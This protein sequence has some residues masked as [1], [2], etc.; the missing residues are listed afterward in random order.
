V[1][2]VVYLPHFL[3]WVVV[4]ALAYTMLSLDNGVVNVIIRA[5][6]GEQKFFL[7]DSSIFRYVLVVVNVWK[8]SG[9]NAII[10]LAA[11][12]GVAAELYEAAA[13]DGASKFQRLWYI[14]LPSFL[15]T[16]TITLLLRIGRILNMGFE[17][18]MA[19]Y[20][21][22]VYEVADVI[23]TYVYRVGLVNQNFSFSAA[24]GLFKSLISLAMVLG[25][26][27]LA[28]RL[29]QESLF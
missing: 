13:I 22:A 28:N 17:Q 2:T 12:T 14:S 16:I 23:D 4:A 19:M 18:I 5:L 8:E 9:W 6:G 3:S 7:G 27:W 10:Y 15:P 20:S 21:P 29:D 11:L 24:V 26:N 1:Q 25:A